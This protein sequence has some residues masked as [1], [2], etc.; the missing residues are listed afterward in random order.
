VVQNIQYK[1]AQSKKHKAQSTKH[2]TDPNSW[3]WYKTKLEQN[4]QKIKKK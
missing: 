3:G 1:T 2:K 4:I